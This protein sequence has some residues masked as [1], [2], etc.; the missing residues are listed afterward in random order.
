MQQRYPVRFAFPSVGGFDVPF[1]IATGVDLTGQLVGGNQ[2]VALIG[3]DVL[4]NCVLTYNGAG[5]F[6]TLAW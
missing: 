5:G 4:A 6:I 3:R 1:N 2:I